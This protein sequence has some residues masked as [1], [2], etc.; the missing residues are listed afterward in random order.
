MEVFNLNIP[1]FSCA[2]QF[3]KEN[4]IEHNNFSNLKI[5]ISKSYFIRQSF[6]VYRCQLKMPL[7]K[8]KITYKVAFF[9]D[10][11]NK[12]RLTYMPHSQTKLCFFLKSIYQK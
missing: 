1:W 11:L 4:T 12:R 10:P 8:C 7:Y 3:C 6:N 5:L 9:T 2:D